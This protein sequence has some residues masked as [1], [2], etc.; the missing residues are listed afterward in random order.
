MT[1]G[2]VSKE[3]LII[4]VH[5]LAKVEHQFRRLIKVGFMAHMTP[6]TLSGV[7]TNALSVLL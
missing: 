5:S 1:C 3:A 7:E 2:V 6:T 4:I